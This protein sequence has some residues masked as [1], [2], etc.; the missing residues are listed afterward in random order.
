M[1]RVSYSS[2][3]AKVSQR[4]ISDS[5]PNTDLA[6]TCNVLINQW[7]S[8]FWDQIF[9]PEWSPV[10]QRQFRDNWNSATTYAA[11]AL[12]APVEVYYAP[13]DRYYQSLHAANLNNAPATLS[14]GSYVE[15][16]A[17]W[18]E[19]ASDYTTQ[20]WTAS[21]AY[22][23]GQQVVN[24]N[25]NQPYQCITAHT[26]TSTFDGTK[27]GL[28]T[29]FLRNISLTQTGQNEISSVEGVYDADPRII[30]EAQRV[31][32]RLDSAGILVRGIV[33]RPWIR[34]RKPVSSWTGSVYDSTL[35]YNLADQVY[36]NGDYYTAI[37]SVPAATTPA[38][39]AY[40]TVIPFPYVFRD[41]VPQ[42]AY[43]DFLRTD[44]QNEKADAEQ[45]KALQLLS[46]EI[47]L[48]ERQQG[49]TRTL[50]VIRQ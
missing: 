3:L 6:A 33:T 14:G 2:V 37:Q 22:T 24:P 19:S 46:R 10:E 29:P 50:P 47:E 17:H 21:T 30:L 28:L 34:Y 43:S 44:G 8:V 41:A 12:N 40:W 48:L 16:S 38:N 42:A 9:W 25:D 36:Y 27:F 5:A 26:S 49:Q 20:T 15:N 35:S 1:R 31:R 13:A 7:A 32:F 45:S 11:P 4:A 39:T 23:V 18:A